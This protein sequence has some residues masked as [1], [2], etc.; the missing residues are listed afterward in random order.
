MLEQN[1]DDRIISAKERRQMIP[2][3]DMQIWRLE[4]EGKFPKRIQLG[5]KRIGWSLNE[6]NQWMGARKAERCA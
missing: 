5:P 2:Y 6:I 3:S 4:N 1:L